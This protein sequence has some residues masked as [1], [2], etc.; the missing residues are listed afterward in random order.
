MCA[1]IR[2]LPHQ[3]A[4]DDSL[5]LRCIPLLP[6]WN[7]ADIDETQLIPD[8]WRCNTC[9][10]A[11]MI[12]TCQ[13]FTCA[14]RWRRN[15]CPLSSPTRDLS[16]GENALGWLCSSVLCSYSAKATPNRDQQCAVRSRIGGHMPVEDCA[17]Q[18]FRADPSRKRHDRNR[19]KSAVCPVC[20]HFALFLTGWVLL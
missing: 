11:V 3:L 6:T 7:I 18:R 5:Q 2:L 9:M 17:V 1:R 16:N 12:S 20:G 14:G 13:R 4:A 10:S 15:T 19:F 8:W